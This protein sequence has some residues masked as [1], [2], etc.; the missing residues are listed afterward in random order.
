VIDPSDV[1]KFDRSIWE[2]QEFWLFC[3]VVAGKTARVQARLLD[4][5]LKLLPPAPTPFAQMALGEKQ[6]L[7][8]GALKESRLGQ[9][10]RL[11]VCFVQ[12]LGLDLQTCTIPDLEAVYGVGPKTARMFLMHSRPDQ[13]LAALD[14]HLLKHLRANGYP[15]APEVT[16][17][18]AKTYHLY[19]EA[20]LTLA[21]KAGMSAATYDLEIWKMYSASHRAQE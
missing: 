6:G 20:F 15:H 10:N 17:S 11:H 19:E 2:L 5:F 3:C 4:G 18:S 16:P 7:L 13:R 9:Y 8:Y 14:T 21:D 1:I 12:S